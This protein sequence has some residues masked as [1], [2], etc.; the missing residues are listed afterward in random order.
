MLLFRVYYQ[1]IKLHLKVYSSLNG[2]KFDK[3]N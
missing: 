2:L 3:L 1:F